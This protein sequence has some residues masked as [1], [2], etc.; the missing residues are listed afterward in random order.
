MTTKTN[1]FIVLLVL[2][3]IAIP[4]VGIIFDYQDC[5]QD[6]QD[7]EQDCQATPVKRNC[8]TSYSQTI[9]VNSD[10]IVISGNGPQN[11]QVTNNGHTIEI[12]SG[13][14]SMSAPQDEV[15]ETTEV[16][17]ETSVK[18]PVHHKAVAKA[19][20]PFAPAHP[21]DMSGYQF[22]DGFIPDTLNPT[23]N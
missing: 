16:V 5:E 12:N 20:K 19:P 8:C 17:E 2:L 21:L 10:Y 11:V 4:V 23:E 18:K 6:C 9:E 7:C 15:I 1:F 13:N 3:F 14:V 22:Q